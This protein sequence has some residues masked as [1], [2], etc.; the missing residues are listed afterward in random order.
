MSFDCVIPVAGRDCIL[1]RRILP[2][3]R[4]N[5]ECSNIFIILNN[6]FFFYF[7]GIKHVRLID[8]DKLYEGLTYDRV[9]KLLESRG[10]N[11]KSTGWYYQQFIKMSFSL[12][13]YC[14]DNYL[15][16]DSDT[17][18]LKT[19]R[20]FSDGDKPYFTMKDE[21]HLPYFITTD[22]LLG[23]GK[24]HEKSFI[25]E[26]MIFKKSLMLEMINSIDS[27]SVDGKDWIEKIINSLPLDCDNCFSEFETYGT[28][29]FL[30]YKEE[31]LYRELATYR[32]AGEKISRIFLTFSLKNA[33]YKYD[34]ISLEHQ[35]T[36]S[37]W[38]YLFDFFEKVIIHYIN[39]TLRLF[40]R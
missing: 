27:S 24:S 5:I 25:S 3:I 17:I 33:N 19:I 4:K 10:F 18:P 36:P 23:F 6:R 14:K 40:K 16:W 28:Y 1:L 26:N 11:S 8:E 9:Q 35:H 30:K 37:G 38:Y 20:F 2:I 39:K 12:S 13:S 31:Y 29:V 21:F 15:T 22:K 34:L 7:K 32:C